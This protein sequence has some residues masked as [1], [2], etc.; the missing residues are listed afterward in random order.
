[1]WCLQRQ[2]AHQQQTNSEQLSWCPP[3]QSPMLSQAKASEG[4][5]SGWAPP[6]RLLLSHQSKMQQANRTA[7][8]SARPSFREHKCWPLRFKNRWKNILASDS[9]RREN[10]KCHGAPSRR[11]VIESP[12]WLCCRGLPWLW[13]K[14]TSNDRGPTPEPRLPGPLEDLEPIH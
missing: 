7:L 9:H 3:T 14:L 12:L 11:P 10:R 8:Q 4:G 6:P 2:R 5:L 1:M 13:L